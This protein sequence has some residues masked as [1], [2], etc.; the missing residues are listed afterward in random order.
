MVNNACLKKIT[1]VSI[2]LISSKALLKPT[3]AR[4]YWTPHL[5]R[6]TKIF[7][8]VSVRDKSYRRL[9]IVW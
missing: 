2:A 4:H 6:S 8:L 3:K 1:Y 9:F 7:F 5:I